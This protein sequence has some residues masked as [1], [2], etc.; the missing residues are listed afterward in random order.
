MPDY[1]RWYDATQVDTP[2]NRRG[3]VRFFEKNTLGPDG[4]HPKFNDPEGWDDPS[5]TIY[6]RV[7]ADYSDPDILK[8][9]SLEAAVELW[10]KDIHV[11][12]NMVAVIDRMRYASMIYVSEDSDRLGWPVFTSFVKDGKDIRCLPVYTRR[13]KAANDFTGTF[14]CHHIKI[15][16]II[17]TCEREGVKHVVLNPGENHGIFLADNLNTCIDEYRQIDK[18][19]SGIRHGGVSGEDLFP[20][21][22]QDFLQRKVGC[23]YGNGKTVQ[24]YCLPY[25]TGTAPGYVILTDSRQRVY[26]PL[27]NLIGIYELP[28]KTK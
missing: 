12:T 25:S 15:E 1:N 22:A 11:H 20:L 13:K 28:N 10:Q 7:L 19:W 26:I 24:G 18:F 6:L 27:S 8:P 5:V 3:M 21:L 17:D 14:Y 2:E 4:K 16:E 9:E 23:I